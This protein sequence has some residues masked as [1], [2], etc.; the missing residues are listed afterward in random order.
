MNDTKYIQDI[1]EN[2]AGRARVLAS[3]TCRDVSKVF[4]LL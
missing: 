4:G 1:L 2:G 3:K